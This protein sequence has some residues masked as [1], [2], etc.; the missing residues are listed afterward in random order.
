VHGLTNYHSHTSSDIDFVSK[1]LKL[2]LHF[3]SPIPFKIG[4]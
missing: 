4:K 3:L 2:T 1:K